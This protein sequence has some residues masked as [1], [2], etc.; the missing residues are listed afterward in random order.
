M[1]A[2]KACF[3]FIFIFI[4][5]FQ[6]Y[7]GGFEEIIQSSLL[8]Y[9]IQQRDFCVHF[10]WSLTVI[11]SRTHTQ[12]ASNARQITS[13][14]LFFFFHAPKTLNKPFEFLLYKT[15]RLQIPVCVSCNRPQKTSQRVKNNS[16]A[17]R[18]RFVSYFLFFIRTHGKM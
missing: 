17:T 11:Y 7:G 3:I 8:S 2:L 9:I 18:L 15:N 4:F 14:D 12:M 6:N 16:H 13:A 5:S 1:S 10:H